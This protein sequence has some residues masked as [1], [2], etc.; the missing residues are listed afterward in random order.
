MVA[1][2]CCCW[3]QVKH[4]RKSTSCHV[5]AHTDRLFRWTKFGVQA[6]DEVLK[7]FDRHVPEFATLVGE[8]TARVAARLE[9]KDPAAIKYLVDAKLSTSWRSVKSENKNMLDRVREAWELMG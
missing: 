9:S 7:V 4:R 6:L 3:T 2:C 5:R 8:L 1:V